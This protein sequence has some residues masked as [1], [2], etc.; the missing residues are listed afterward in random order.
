MC[1]YVEE[2]FIKIIIADGFTKNIMITL[3]NTYMKE[4]IAKWE[5]LKNKG[6]SMLRKGVKEYT[7]NDKY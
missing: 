3:Y 4:Y 1:K 7:T 2:G 6:H 5:V